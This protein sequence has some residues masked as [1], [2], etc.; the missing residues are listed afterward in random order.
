MSKPIVVFGAGGHA[1]AVIDTIEKQGQYKIAGLLDANKSVGQMVYGY[2]ILGDDSWMETHAS[3]I[4]GAIVAIGDNWIR[5]SIVHKLLL[6]NPQ[7]LFCTAIHPSAQIARGARIGAGSVIMAGAVVNSDTAIGEH[8]ILYPGVS[9]D[10]DSHIGSFVSFA[11]KSATG[12]NVR[13][14]QYSAVA[15]G[16]T[17]IHGITIGDHSVIG[18]GSTVLSDIPSQTIAYGTPAKPIR[19]REQ[20]ERYL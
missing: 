6:A 2:E 8:S 12:G 15:I 1:K 18:A 10:H 11:P 17:I 14:G 3:S 16:T 20:G 5:G 7:L 9:V 13:I 19:N 4:S